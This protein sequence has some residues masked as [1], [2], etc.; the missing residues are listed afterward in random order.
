MCSSFY[1]LTHR[2]LLIMLKK[3][4][5]GLLAQK[6]GENLPLRVLKNGNGM[7]YIGTFSELHGPFTRESKEYWNS[8]HEAETALTNRTWTQRQHN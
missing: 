6:A 2:E 3:D 1:F 8:A 7:Y 4:S 5:I